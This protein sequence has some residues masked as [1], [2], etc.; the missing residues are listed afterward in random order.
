M[1]LSLPFKP[2]MPRFQKARYSIFVAL[3]F[4]LC[5][6][7]VRAFCPPSMEA[8]KWDLQRSQNVVSRRK[9]IGATLATAL[10]GIKPTFVTAAEETVAKVTAKTYLDVTIGNDPAGRVVIGLYGDSAPSTVANFLKVVRGEYRG[11]I[12][13]DGSS[14]TRVESGSRID[15]GKLPLG[16]DKYETRAID[17]TGRVRRT[18]RNA[19]EDLA[20]AEVNRL[21]HDRPGVVSTRIGGATF[22]F[23]IATE[24]NPA[25]DK[26][27]IVF[28]EVLEGMDTV[29]KMEAVPVS[30]EDP[31]GSKQRFAAAGKNFDPRAKLASIYRPLRK[32]VVTKAGVL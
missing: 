29:R 28:G 22:E 2:R 25:L 12:S 21:H 3:A 18:T 20:T 1:A 9:M 13:Y 24:P 7:H 30:R 27:N 11:E 23:T 5:P 14:V 6:L 16:S 31:I 4:L 32:I 10:V 8:S 19:A 15:L 17:G 26:E